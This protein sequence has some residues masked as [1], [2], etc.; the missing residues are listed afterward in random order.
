M[1]FNLHQLLMTMGSYLIILLDMYLVVAIASYVAICCNSTFKV[2]LHGLL[3]LIAE[4][5]KHTSKSLHYLLHLSL[6]HTVAS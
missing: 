2:R 6:A 1:R 4:V 3:K 5:K